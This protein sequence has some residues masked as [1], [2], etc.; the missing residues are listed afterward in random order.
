MF[1]DSV[2]S[3]VVHILTH[4]TT[5]LGLNKI[6]YISGM[7]YSQ[8]LYSLSIIYT[9]W[10]GLEDATN[11]SHRPCSKTPECWPVFFIEDWTMSEQK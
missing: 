9:T 4:K 11:Q 3:T 2:K 8:P 5:K 7:F 10:C 6:L 1:L